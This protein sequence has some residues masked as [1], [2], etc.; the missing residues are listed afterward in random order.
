M[1]NIQTQENKN[2]LKKKNSHITIFC[3]VKRKQILTKI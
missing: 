1:I 3:Q 2:D